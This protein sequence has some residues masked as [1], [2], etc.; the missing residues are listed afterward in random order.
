[1][2][3]LMFGCPSL[4]VLPTTY[5]TCLSKYWHSRPFTGHE[6]CFPGISFP[7]ALLLLSL[8]DTIIAALHSAVGCVTHCAVW[9]CLQLVPLAAGCIQVV[10]WRCPLHRQPRCY[11]FSTHVRTSTPHTRRHRFIVRERH[12]VTAGI[13]PLH[14]VVAVVVVHDPP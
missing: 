5:P 10:C 1:M 13:A 4:R 12:Y 7:F 2:R 11:A 9:C 8:L 3:V 14:T 6:C